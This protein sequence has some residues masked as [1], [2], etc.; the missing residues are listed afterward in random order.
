VNGA[1][2]REIAAAGPYTSTMPSLATLG[3]IAR[4]LA[5]DH[6]RLGALLDE[7][8]ATPGAVARA[9]YDAFRA[10]LLRHIALEEKILLRAARDARGGEPLPQARRLRID[11]GAI[12]SLL[13]PPP[14][15]ALAA[16]LRS[17][18]DPHNLVEEEPG[19]LYDT[20]DRLLASQASEILARMAAYPPVKVAAYYDGPRVLRT[21]AEALRLMQ[22]QVP[23]E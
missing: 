17:I 12:A 22:A 23:K 3:P 21:A 14:T 1:A 7:A 16:E 18:L 15:P 8:L 2:A 9:P 4:T 6:D 19:G 11:H 5:E 10:G 13:V 20:C